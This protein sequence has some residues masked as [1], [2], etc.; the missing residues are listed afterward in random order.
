MLVCVIGVERNLSVVSVEQQRR[1][2]MSHREKLTESFHLSK[3]PSSGLKQALMTSNKASSSSTQKL[4]LFFIKPELFGTQL[5]TWSE[6]STGKRTNYKTEGEILN[7]QKEENH[8]KQLVGEK[9]I[10]Y[11]LKQA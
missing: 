4:F 1:A 7:R 5:F 8:F 2:E 11:N 6:G 3:P 9:W 10:I